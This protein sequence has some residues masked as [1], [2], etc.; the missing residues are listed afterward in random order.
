MM[1]IDFC[2]SHSFAWTFQINRKLRKKIINEEGTT[3][4]KCGRTIKTFK[5]HLLKLILLSI[6]PFYFFL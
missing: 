3:Q 4:Q 1:Q 6:F 5:A 2:S